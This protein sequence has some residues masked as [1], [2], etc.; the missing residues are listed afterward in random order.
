M[1]PTSSCPHVLVF[2]FPVQSHASAMI[3]LAE[4]LCLTDL[5]VT[6]LN[7]DYIQSRLLRSSDVKS[8]FGQYPGFWFAAITDR[9]LEDHPRC[10]FEA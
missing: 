1:N 10:G 6:F 9:L 3:K 8:R 7:S 2:P 5:N 4:L